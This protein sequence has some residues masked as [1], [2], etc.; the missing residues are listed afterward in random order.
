MKRYLTPTFVMIIALLLILLS[1]RECSRPSGKPLIADTIIII[2]D[3]IHADT[4]QCWHNLPA[5]DA[6]TVFFSQVPILN[7]SLA[8]IDYNTVKIYNRPLWDDKWAKVD[9]TDT[10]WRNSLLGSRIK[11]KFF[12]HDTTFYITKIVNTPPLPR[13][14]AFLGFETGMIWPGKMIV[15][16][17]V[18]VLSK[19]DHLYTFA[20]DP[21]NKAG[22]G[23]ILWKI[24]IRKVP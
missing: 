1:Y 24:R 17:S 9:L 11:T 19:R 22:S 18:A 20:Y 2:H 4:I 12:T 6:D 7:D 21:F 23:T 15:G 3:S 8:L 5:P 14:K 13:F 16:P 10:I